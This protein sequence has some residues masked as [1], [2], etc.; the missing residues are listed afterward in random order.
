MGSLDR[1][2]SGAGSLDRN[3]YRMIGVT[4]F[5]EAE[6]RIIWKKHKGPIPEGMH[7]HHKD[8]DKLNNDIDNLELI[9]PITHRRLHC[10][11]KLVDDVWHKPCRSCGALLPYEAFYAKP[12]KNGP[13]T[14]WCCKPCYNKKVI[15]RRRGK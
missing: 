6:H 9:D 8:E 15:E 7:V 14:Q 13:S 10:G 11:H 3:G 1:A 12:G 4:K 5:Y 2:P